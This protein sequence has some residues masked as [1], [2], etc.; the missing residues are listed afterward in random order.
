[1]LSVHHWCP[2]PR[3]T[4]QAT[5]IVCFLPCPQ[6]EGRGQASAAPGKIITGRASKRHLCSCIIYAEPPFPS[7]HVFR[8]VGKEG[9]AGHA[10]HPTDCSCL[11]HG[12]SN[13]YRAG[14]H[15]PWVQ[16][17]CSAIR[18]GGCGPALELSPVSLEVTVC[19]AKCAKQP[20]GGGRGD[21]VSR[22]RFLKAEMGNIQCF[23]CFN[24]VSSGVT[25]PLI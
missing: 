24:M 1:M 2:L 10:Q 14:N 11:L 6:G 7:L 25:G 17:P 16:G 12:C 22:Q 4:A 23:T 9:Q 13:F 20:W 21:R 5:S 19:K 18:V 3:D 8:E 15:L